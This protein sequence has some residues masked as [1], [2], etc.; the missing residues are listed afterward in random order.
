V[1]ERRQDVG[2]LTINDESAVLR[3]GSYNA[4]ATV[5]MGAMALLCLT[6]FIIEPAGVGLVGLVLSLTMGTFCVRFAGA[7]IRAERDRL[8]LRSPFRTTVLAWDQVRVAAV[9]P[10]NANRLFAVV[11]VVTSDGRRVKVDGPGCRWRKAGNDETP[12]G[13]MVA[14]INRRRTSTTES[15]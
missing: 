3:G 14:E 10:T 2:V 13:R 11:K 5:L 7:E 15:D 4:A 8:V 1:S 12:V 9:A 6:P